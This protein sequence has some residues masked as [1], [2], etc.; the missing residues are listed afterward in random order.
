M[1]ENQELLEQLQEMLHWKKNSSYYAAKLGI[2]VEE[3]ETLRQELKGRKKSESVNYMQTDLPQQ[4]LTYYVTTTIDSCSTKVNNEKGTLESTIEISFEPK[5]DI[6]LAKLHKINLDKYKISN[7]WTKQKP[8]GK[9]TSSVFAT[10]KKAKD[11]SPEDFAKFLENYKPAELIVRGVYGE[12]EQEEVDIEISIADFHLAKKTLEGETIQEKKNQYLGVVRDLV[13]KIRN[14]HKINKIVFPISNDF[15]HT[16]NYQNQ[17][18]NLTPQ[19]TLTSYD[20]EYEQGF[21]LL[22]TTIN[23]LQT[24]ASNVEVILVQ[25]NHDRTKSFYLAHALEIFFKSNEKISFQREHS[26]TKH[27]VLGNT[28]I[29]YHH[30]NCKI[31]DLPLLFAT[32]NNSASQFGNAVY[33]EVHTGDKH[34]YM[35][36]EIKGVRIQQMPSLSGTDR[37]HLDNNFV[38]NIRAGLALIYHPL[39][40]KIGEFESRI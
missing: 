5:D 1:Q 17:T 38:N 19:D 3:V 4:E 25:G 16:D 18:T 10:L 29:G 40:G 34:H 6:E 20:N 30:G 23:Y 26:V 14:S 21:D 36:K 2:T 33:R 32:N 11:Y 12:M 8:N 22:V 31:D 15:F 24:I 9:F 39:Y 37:W 35:A 28:F 13:E 7:Y 27:T